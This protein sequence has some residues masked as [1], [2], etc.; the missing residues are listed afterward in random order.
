[1]D[2]L[3]HGITQ[4]TATTPSGTGIS[5]SR[6]LNTTR[7]V[8]A[9]L[10]GITAALARLMTQTVR[11]LG[12]SEDVINQTTTRLPQSCRKLDRCIP[13]PKCLA[14]FV[15]VK[16]G[17]WAVGEEPEPPRGRQPRFLHHLDLRFTRNYACVS[18]KYLL[19]L[20]YVNVPTPGCRLPNIC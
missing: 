8:G 1:M 17:Y 5:G 12:Q 10:F 7:R 4:R 9:A 16:E 14:R 20:Y 11:T 19:R 15:C 6:N 3:L 18:N 13:C 2:A